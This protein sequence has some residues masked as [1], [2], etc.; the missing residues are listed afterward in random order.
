MVFLN[1]TSASHMHMLP[2]MSFE[3][4]V[5]Y[6]TLVLFYLPRHSVMTDALGATNGGK[7]ASQPLCLQSLL[8]F[9][10][11]SLSVT[12]CPADHICLKQLRCEQIEMFK[13]KHR[14]ARSSSTV[15]IL[16]CV[17]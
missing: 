11:H 12:C 5:L 6:H 15:L 7:Q 16:K 2:C 9:F 8:H 1:S 14:L 17:L 4:R 3:S 13:S 10:Y